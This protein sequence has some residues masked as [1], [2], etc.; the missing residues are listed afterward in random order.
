MENKLEAGEHLEMP[1]NCSSD[2]HGLLVKCW[3]SEQDSRPTATYAR[4]FFE[5]RLP[6]GN[7]GLPG[8]EE[9]DPVDYQAQ[10]HT[11]T[12]GPASQGAG[13]RDAIAGA[14]ATDSVTVSSA[15]GA[16]S[17]GQKGGAK[18]A[19][20]TRTSQRSGMF[21]L[22]KVTSSHQSVAA[23]RGSDGDIGG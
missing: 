9:D 16:P 6:A 5:S 13:S 4:E 1:R 12:S 21:F 3:E 20:P 18:T 8:S 15:F 22:L 19:A 7:I 2:V 11:E 14:E 23:G 17:L 10:Q